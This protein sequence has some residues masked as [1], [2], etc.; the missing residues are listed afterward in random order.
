M[1]D[2]HGYRTR[3]IMLRVGRVQKK[4]DMGR[5]KFSRFSR[6]NALV[7]KLRHHTTLNV[8]IAWRR[9]RPSTPEGF[10]MLDHMAYEVRKN[11]IHWTV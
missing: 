4:A 10:D 7:A 1:S 9:T 5:D 3:V 2:R 8:V 6:S 11:I